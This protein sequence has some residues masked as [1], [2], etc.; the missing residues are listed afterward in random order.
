MLLDDLVTTIQTVQARIRDHGNIFSQNEYRTRISLIDPIL[1]ALG[2]DVS[3]PG[4]VT[5]DYPVGNVRAN[6]ALL[7]SDGEPIAFVK[8]TPLNEALD[9]YQD[10]SFE[11]ARD[12][13]LFYS[14]LTNGNRWVF[15]KATSASQI[16]ESRILD[17]R[18][19]KETPTQS[20]SQ[21]L[22]IQRPIQ[23]VRQ[24]TKDSNSI[25]V[26]PT[27][28]ESPIS[29]PQPPMP[30]PIRSPEWTEHMEHLWEVEH[31]SQ[32]TSLAD[33]QI[34]P[35]DIKNNKARD[36][37]HIRLRTPDGVDLSVGKWVD[38]LVLTAEWLVRAGHLTTD[39]CPVV[40]DKRSFISID[41]R[42]TTG[43]EYQSPH[44]LSNG[45][46]LN[47]RPGNN[48]AYDQPLR[49]SRLLIDHCEQDPTSVFLKR[50]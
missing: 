36:P 12:K 2:W 42:N 34:E 45:L 22:L 28:T 47:K 26:T 27:D 15:R 14:G 5:P 48:S 21:L 29:I 49:Y 44:K 31:P 10:Q 43:N 30:P 4:L 25:L 1:N 20:A 46:F 33:F 8:P 19:S 41:G 6:Y 32:W 7:G 13:N 3:D 50:G 35:E 17:V 16:P 39:H 23:S 38:L 9:V 37:N 40:V 18:I 24:P 11:Y